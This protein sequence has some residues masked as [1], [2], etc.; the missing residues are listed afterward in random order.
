[1]RSFCQ[2]AVFSIL[3]LVTG[4]SVHGQDKKSQ[5]K[6]SFDVKK[7]L[8]RLDV[9]D[10]G[11]VEKSEITDDRT[12]SFLKKSGADLSKPINIKSFVKKQKEDREER[13]N[14]KSSSSKQLTSGFAVA[15]SERDVPAGDSRGF[16]VSDEE[17]APV[18]NALSREFSDGTKKMLSWVLNNYDKNGDGIIDA[19]EIKAARWA[20]PPANESDTNGDGSLSKL[21]LLVR[22]QNREDWKSEKRKNSGYSDRDYDRGRDRDRSKS[23]KYRKSSRS[24]SASTGNR[25]VR[26]GY[27]S[28]VEGIFK[29]YD[30]NS[31]K[32]LDEKELEKM[33]RKPDK[34]VDTNGDKKI[35][36]EELLESYLEKANQS[37]NRKSSSKSRTSTSSTRSTVSA[38][39]SSPDARSPLTNRDKNK[40]GQIEMAE[41]ESDWTVEKIEEFYK[42][43]KNRDG[44]ITRKEW[45]AK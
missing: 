4:I 11:V 31:D 13:K 26:K 38:G 30:K 17:R 29:S 36:Q 8:K 34:S 22:Y 40:N 16:A 2:I 19:K 21:E 12:K 25:D 37:S 24:D 28:Y 27:E 14:R 5:R 7:F 44:V 33:R 1:M 3:V 20:D 23:E 39:S 41:Y 6:P 9:N 45:E 32:L 43:D 42:K 18:T 15:D 35:S 10:N